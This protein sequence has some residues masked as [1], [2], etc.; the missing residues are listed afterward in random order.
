M[1]NHRVSSPE[2]TSPY[3]AGGQAAPAGRTSEG[4]V[5]D[6]V[7]VWSQRSRI[8]LSPIA[9][10]SILGLFGFFVATVMVG[11][12]LAGWWGGPTAGLSLWPFALF[13]GG[14][15]Q[16]LAA[17][18]SYKARDGLATAVHGAWGS[19]WLAWGVMQL[20]LATHVMAPV[21]LAT[22]NPAFAMWFVG[23]CALT[24]MAAFASLAESLGIF[25]VLATLAGGSGVFAA[26]LWAGNVTVDRIAG[27]LFVISAAAAW[28]TASAMMLTS[29]T[30]RTILPLGKWKASANIPMRSPVTPIEYA[31]GEPGVRVGQ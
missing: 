11:T 18:W 15:A 23:L 22:T 29:A 20:L 8:V 14:L 16:L 30:G 4:E 21:P 9:A 17:M 7:Q 26:G 5:A 24:G 19:F 10:P 13:F 6:A 3:P 12:N 25:T 31:E 2:T 1:A 27:W 28:Y